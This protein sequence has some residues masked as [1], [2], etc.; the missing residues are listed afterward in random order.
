MIFAH[1]KTFFRLFFTLEA[2]KV[3]KCPE[4]FNGWQFSIRYL[5]F[6]QTEEII[7]ASWLNILP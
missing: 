3:S 6:F 1:V 4:T 5:Y 7:I 2:Q